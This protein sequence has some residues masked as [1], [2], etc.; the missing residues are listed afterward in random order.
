[1]TNAAAKSFL[2]LRNNIHCTLLNWHECSQRLPCSSWSPWPWGRGTRMV[3]VNYHLFVRTT[4]RQISEQFHLLMVFKDV[5]HLV[6]C[7]ENLLFLA[8]HVFL[9]ELEE[10]QLQKCHR[11]WPSGGLSGTT[12]LLISFHAGLV[13]VAKRFVS[14]WAALSYGYRSLQSWPRHMPRSIF[15][16]C[17]AQRWCPAM[18]FGS[19]SPYWDS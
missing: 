11:P 15:F 17:Q 18:H 12:G 16:V 8:V 5:A 1:M 6:H 13:M 14:L 9:W 7:K 2:C 4:L 19:Q 3:A 10:T